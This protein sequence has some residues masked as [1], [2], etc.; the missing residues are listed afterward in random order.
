MA[1]VRGLTIFHVTIEDY[2]QRNLIERCFNKLKQSRHIAM[3]F[4]RNPR[5]YLAMIKLASTCLW[6]SPYE[7]AA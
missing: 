2:K 6:L 7:P 3:R 4:D 5:N 1:Q